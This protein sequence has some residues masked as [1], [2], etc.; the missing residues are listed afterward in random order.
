[1][2]R[3]M[4][5]AAALIVLLALV[6]VGAVA[7]WGLRPL[8][9]RTDRVE[10]SIEP[11]TSS[12]DIARAWVAAGVDVNPM[13]LHE[14]FRWS[15]QSRKI[16]AGSYEIERGTTALEL[17]RRMVRGDQIL[18]SLRL[19]DGWNFRQ[20]RAA[21]AKAPHLR[22]T[23][24]Q[25]T[26]TQVAAALGMEDGQLEGWLYPDTYAYSPGVTDLTVLRRAHAA[27]QTHLE[28]AWAVRAQNTPLKS[29]KDLLILASVVEKET[30]QAADRPLVAAV[31]SN[32]LRIGMPLQSDPTVI[33]GLGESY[34]GNLHKVDLQTDTPWNTYV[35]KGLPPTPIAMPGKQ[36]L[37]ATAH[38]ASSDAL[39]FVA[40]GD[41][42]SAFSDNLADHNRAVN[43]Y[44]R[45]ASR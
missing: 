39:Y 20:V 36:A 22:H 31:F 6:T 2:K 38:P 12:R 16:Q 13:L 5:R 10:V 45:G 40:K 3:M 32:R 1:M 43:Q 35:R 27:M 37:M 11:G 23:V 9:M 41:G 19:I 29:P 8:P 26:D 17:L 4:K 25:M 28:E 34:D 44:Q 30:G 15:G 21:L 7:W 33:Y 14:W 24:D 42:T 18:Q